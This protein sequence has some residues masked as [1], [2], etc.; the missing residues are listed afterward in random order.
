MKYRL[1]TLEG[2]FIATDAIQEMLL[3][4]EWGKIKLFPAIPSH[5]T[6][7]EFENFRVFGGLLISSKITDNKISYVKIKA[8]ADCT[9]KIE[10]DL[11]HLNCNI[12]INDTKKWR[13]FAK[14]NNLFVIFCLFYYKFYEI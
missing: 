10:N 9:F 2:N 3:Y 14:K 7:A 11:S 5:W 6:D 13:D 8:T 4:S 12:K 1:F